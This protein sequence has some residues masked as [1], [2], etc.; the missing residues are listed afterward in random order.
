MW[1]GGGVICSV[2]Y[3][4]RGMCSALYTVKCTVGG[5][6]WRR[7]VPHYIPEEGYVP[8]YIRYIYL[9]GDFSDQPIFHFIYLI[10]LIGQK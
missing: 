8:H 1:G 4:W 7:Y 10:N 6:V 5:D 9:K 2:L 3:I